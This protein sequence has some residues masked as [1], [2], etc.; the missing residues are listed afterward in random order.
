MSTAA[1]GPVK[2]GLALD[3]LCC[4][5]THAALERSGG[6]LVSSGSEKHRYP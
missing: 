3:L 6:E 5:L 1:Q 2:N 4:P